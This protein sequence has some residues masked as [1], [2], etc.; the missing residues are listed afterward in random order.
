MTRERKWILIIGAVLLL[1]G[2]VI[3]F[4]PAGGPGT[5]ADSVSDKILEKYRAKAAERD[6]LQHRLL[7]ME[8]SLG[9]AEALLLSGG[10]PAL[11]A[12]DI[13]NH[14]GGLAE[15]IGIHMERMQVLPVVEKEENA[16]VRIPVRMNVKC[17]AGQL[18]DILYSLETS[19]TL[20]TVTAVQVRRPV[21]AS[22]GERLQV[23]IT[24]AG[25][26]KPAGGQPPK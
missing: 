4:I 2:A 16:Y 15:K 20:L 13:Q 18:R 11:A 25:L 1:I 22:A 6:A 21:G 9:R 26:M 19:D 7:E 24:V 5:K 10:T 8:R 14:L 12:V 17:S 23:Q 3:R